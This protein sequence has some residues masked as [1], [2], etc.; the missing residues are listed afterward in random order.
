MPCSTVS[1]DGVPLGPANRT[2]EWVCCLG[3]SYWIWQ[4]LGPLV[5]GLVLARRTFRSREVQPPSSSSRPLARRALLVR[6]GCLSSGYISSTVRLLCPIRLNAACLLW[7]ADGL[8]RTSRPPG[9]RCLAGGSVLRARARLVRLKA[10][11]AG[12]PL[13]PRFQCGSLWRPAGRR[14]PGACSRSGPSPRG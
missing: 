14:C 1:S 3:T 12:G 5:F 9:R 10:M 8:V 13:R 4:D 6:A 11:F 2:S 7:S